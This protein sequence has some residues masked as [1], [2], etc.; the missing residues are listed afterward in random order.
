MFNKPSHTEKPAVCHFGK[1]QSQ[2]LLLTERTITQMLPLQISNF[3]D[4]IYVFN[5]LFIFYI[6]LNPILNKYQL[7]ENQNIDINVFHKS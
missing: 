4:V 1:V 3:F 2:N 5:V 7:T 6:W